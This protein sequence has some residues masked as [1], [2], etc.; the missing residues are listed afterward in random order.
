MYGCS[1]TLKIPVGAL[2]NKVIFSISKRNNAKIAD[3]IIFILCAVCS[4]EQIYHGVKS[5]FSKEYIPESIAVFAVLSGI[6][7]SLFTIIFIPF[8]VTPKLYNFP[9]ALICVLSLLFSYINVAREKYSFSIVSSKDTK[10]VLNK[11]AVE[12]AEAETEAFSTASKDFM[13]DLIRV[14]KADF[15]K[16]YFARTNKSASTAKVMHPYYILAILIP[17]VLS[18][19]SI[20]KG[21]DFMQAMTNWYVGIMMVLPVGVLFTYSIPFFIGNKRLY[22]YETSIIGEETIEEFANAKAVSVNDTTAFPP[23][24][25]KL[26]NLNVYN[27]YKL[28]KVLYYAVSGFSTVGGPLADVFEVTTKDAFAKSKRARFVCSGRSYLCIKVDNDTIIFAD[29]YGITSQG[30]EIP[31][32]REEIDEDV[33]VMY[34]ACN[35]KLCARMYIK[36]TIDEEFAEIVKSLNK[37]GVSVGIRSF[38]PNINNE[39]L[40]RETNFKK[41]DLRVIRLTKDEDISKIYEKVDSGIVSKGLS[42]FL[43]KAIPVC[44][45]IAKFR[46]VGTVVKIIASVIGATLLGMCIFGVI[47]L[48]YSILIAAYYAVWMFIMFIISSVMILQ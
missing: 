43:I 46:K 30:I 16:R 20:F 44:K 25:V 31:S 29:R 1:T 45:N 23:Y 2:E 15:V 34:M 6:L 21:A 12:D 5:I 17:L 37:N 11:V 4:Y 47:P 26:Q 24:N 9:S 32:E 14:D 22:E 36:Y 3:I 10:F 38:D 35:G 7:H 8:S 41:V 39:L 40:K 42:K 18:I 27:D 28:E 13:G 33:S 19:I 48:I